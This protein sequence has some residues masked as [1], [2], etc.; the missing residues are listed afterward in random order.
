MPH[1]IV[2]H[3]Y[4]NPVD[5]LRLEDIPEPAAPGLGEVLIMVTKR[6]I[7]NGDLLLVKGGHDPIK[8]K[9]PAAGVTAGCEGVGVIQKIGAGVDG[10][11]GLHVGDRVAFFAVGSWQEEIVVSADFV[12]LVPPD[13]EDDIAAQLFINPIAAM[14]LTRLVAQIASSP[15][16]GVL[17]IGAV[18][19][20]VEDLNGISLDA[21]VVLLSVAGSTVARLAAAVLKA[22]GFTPI[23]LVRSSSSAAALQKATGIVVIAYD[24]EH[25][26]E[27]V[28]EAAGGRKIF[29]GLDAVGGHVGEAMLDLLSPAGTLISYG[30][31]TGEPLP[32]DHVH[33]CMTAKKICGIGM[34]HWT[35]LS[36]ETR[37]ADISYL[38]QMVRDH[39][40]FFQVAGEFPLSAVADAVRLFREPG[41]QGTVLL[42]N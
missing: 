13:L 30:S 14:M 21:G 1:K 36:Y 38:I 18:E 37:A 5:V 19:A 7:H 32:V 8:R 34:V 31:L 23:G 28:R 39:R 9:I 11:R 27:D 10:A 35:Q 6:P 24:R 4:G 40:Q 33:L 2:F 12:A 29:V 25:W 22:Q 17:R 16:A 3:E 41:R 15:Q 26:Q 42:G 20:V